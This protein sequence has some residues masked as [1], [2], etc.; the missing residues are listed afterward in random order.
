MLCVFR[1]LNG[2]GGAAVVIF[3][4]ES[5]STLLATI[6][7]ASFNHGGASLMEFELKTFTVIPRSRLNCFNIFDSSIRRQ[8]TNATNCRKD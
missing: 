6:S 1:F 7:I 3:D 5:S 8:I 2:S 4:F